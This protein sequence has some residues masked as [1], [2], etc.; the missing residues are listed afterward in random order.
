MSR[1]YSPGFERDYL[2]YLSNICNFSFAGTMQPKYKAIPDPQGIS[3]KEAFFFID[4][5]GKNKPCRE[6]ELLDSILLCKASVNFHIKMWA[7]G[8]AEGT[9]ATH[10]LRKDYKEEFG[11]PDWVIDAVE[12][13]KTKCKPDPILQEHIIYTR[14]DTTAD[15]W[16]ATP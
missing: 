12:K 4:S 2:F 13:Q 11:L 14:A 8:R 15:C 1:R 6:P 9:I 16:L 7:E 3:A 5:S 10:E